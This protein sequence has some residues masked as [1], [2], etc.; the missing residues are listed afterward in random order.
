MTE[1][2]PTGRLEAAVGNILRF[3]VTLAA[4]VVAVGGVIYLAR[5]REEVVP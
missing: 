3:G 1:L 5:H 4:T 2:G